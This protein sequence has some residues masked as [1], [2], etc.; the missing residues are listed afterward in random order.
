MTT[1]QCLYKI[2]AALE[3]I[4]EE[5]KTMNDLKLDEW[6]A[7]KVKMMAEK[8]RHEQIEVSDE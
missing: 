3:G 6:N 4:W 7:Q 1:D 2:A 8:E 5:L